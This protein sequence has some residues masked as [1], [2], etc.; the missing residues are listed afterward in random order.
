MG[1]IANLLIL[2]V[3]LDL[4]SQLAPI[5]LEQFGAHRHLLDLPPKKWTGLSCF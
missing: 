1:A 5:H 2:V 4:K 3:C